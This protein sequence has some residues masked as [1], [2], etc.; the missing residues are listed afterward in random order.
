MINLFLLFIRLALGLLFILSGG[1]KLLSAYE[2]FFFVIQNY[3]IFGANPSLFFVSIE[4]I[5]AHAVPW[6]ELLL[7]IFCFTG[8]WL[9]QTLQAL[10]VLESIFIFVLASVLIRGLPIDEC[11]C[12]GEG[13]SLPPSKMIIVDAITFGCV[14]MMIRFKEKFS[15]WAL[16]RA[17]K[18]SDGYNSNK[19]TTHRSN[20][21]LDVPISG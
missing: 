7:G 8:L 21:S 12:F 4:R 6:I 9:K 18:E 10:L 19:E 2:N 5:I 16:D 14:L 3:K 1:H 20:P 15:Y 17:A 13:F 11:G